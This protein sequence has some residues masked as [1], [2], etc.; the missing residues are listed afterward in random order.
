MSEAETALMD[1]LLTVEDLPEGWSLIGAGP[2]EPNVGG[3]TFCGLDQFSRPEAVAGIVEAE[4]AVDPNMGPLLLQRITA[5][6][7]D[8]AIEAFE[9][10]RGVLDACTEWT[11]EDGTTFRISRVEVEPLGDESMGITIAYDVEGFATIYGNYYLS[12]IGGILVIIN[13]L[14]VGELPFEEIMPFAT[15]A[16]ERIQSADFQP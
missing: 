14:G 8:V 13:H 4:F 12:R 11:D 2:D 3:Q 15:T 16:I 6:P 9:H 7:E 10:G 1:M 5:Y